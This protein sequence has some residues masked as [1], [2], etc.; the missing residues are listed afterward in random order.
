M[1]GDLLH[2][3]GN[4]LRLLSHTPEKLTQIHSMGISKWSQIQAAYE[5]V[6]RSFEKTL[7]QGSIFSSPGYVREFLQ[8]KF[9]CLPHEVFLCLYLDSRLH[10][11]ERQELFRGSLTHTTLYP[12]EIL[13]EAFFK[14]A[15]ALIVTHNHPSG[16]PL[17]SLT[18]QE[19]TKTLSKAL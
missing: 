9:G 18:V 1:G 16:N 4:L 6:M 5:L 10:L 12:R 13:K 11:I 17:P 7:P 15:S 19:L 8:A 14:N 2:H 3:F